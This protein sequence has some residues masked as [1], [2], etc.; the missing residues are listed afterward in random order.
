MNTK[1]IFRKAKPVIKMYA[2]KCVQCGMDFICRK[3]DASLCPVCA[4]K[5]IAITAEQLRVKVG[6]D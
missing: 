1:D 5:F 4:E 2:H 3:E 6:V